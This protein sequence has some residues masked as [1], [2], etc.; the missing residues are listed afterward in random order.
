MD[1]ISG[2]PFF[3]SSAEAL[4]STTQTLQGVPEEVKKTYKRILNVINQK[5]VEQRELAKRV[6]M[7]TAYSRRPISINHLDHLAH[8][9][10]AETHPESLKSLK[11]SR[12]IIDACANLITIDS[13]TQDVRFVHPSAQKFLTSPPSKGEA[14]DIRHELVQGVMAHRKIAK[15]FI[16]LLSNLYS[17]SLGDSENVEKCF[18]PLGVLLSEWPHHVLAANLKDLP[19]NDELVILTS[20]FLNKCPPVLTPYTVKS[21]QNT[22]VYFMFTPKTLAKVFHLTY[23]NQPTKPLEKKEL[24]NV[25]GINQDFIVI[26]DDHFAMHYTVSVLKS[27]AVADRLF[28]WSY[29]IN[30]RSQD[31][32]LDIIKSWEVD[33]ESDSPGPIPDECQL[34]PLYS[35]DS[36]EMAG[37]L[38]N[39][40]ASV[41]PQHLNGEVIDP[42]IF[43]V[44]KDN[45][46]VTQLLLGKLVGQ[47]GRERCEVALQYALKHSKVGVLPLLWNQ[48]A[49]I[50]TVVGGSGTILQAVALLGNID[51]MKHL[52]AEGINVNAEG[53]KY[54]SALQA[55]AASGN[56]EAV[57]LLLESKAN[58]NA[59]GGEYGNALQIAVASGNV[60]LVEL[61]LKEKASISAQGVYP[62]A[63]HTAAYCGEVKIM[64]LLLNVG[65]DVDSL[66]GAYG[67]VLQA[68]ISST[69]VT[70]KAIQLLLDHGADVNA[71]GGAYGNA[72]QAAVTYGN[73]DVVQLLL[74][75]GADVNAEGGVFGNA[76][77]AAVVHN[78]VQAV[79]LLLDSG[80]DINAKGG[81]F[82]TAL[83]AASYACHLS[84]I[85]KLLDM[86]ADVNA[87]GGKYGTA[88][89]A[90]FAP[91][92]A[93]MNDLQS[94]KTPENIFR[95]FGLLL[96][97]GAD[98]T[99]YT[100]DSK[101]GSAVAAAQELWK[102]DGISF[103]Q[104]V[105]YVQVLESR[106]A[107]GAEETSQEIKR[108]YPEP[109]RLV[110]IRE[111][112]RTGL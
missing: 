30:H 13:G 110:R 56:V 11:S 48:G 19:S 4:H 106:G 39:S 8:I 58:I 47:D 6:L 63:L 27:T 57:A 69:A 16:S 55:A 108:T 24:M 60:E 20:S 97:H 10:L 89:Q 52:L 98:I 109:K 67:N 72:L 70:V 43:F 9:V 34:P 44:E 40:G 68:V 76:L 77:Q 111:L 21:R 107:E 112:L 35:L 84:I 32:K 38:L 81:I 18:P 17:R 46:D 26:R 91:A 73:V 78:K 51:V 12:D 23:T 22:E 15:R 99:T 104:F 62:N 42:L 5:P 65:A 66:D 86:N 36:N 83:Q 59:Q 82:G 50:D 54:G 14:S 3:L 1:A 92:E 101:Y 37:F 29:P 94:S 93:C 49:D 96:D 31:T 100:A 95:S 28:T 7:C 87:Q 2:Q 71:Q 85:K 105:K 103:S 61:L 41:D 64:Q 45:V 88:L 79:D 53:G 74:D 80:A 33:C 90:I 102:N 25:H 75:Y